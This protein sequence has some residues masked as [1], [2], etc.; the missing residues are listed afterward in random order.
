MTHTA[1]GDAIETTPTVHEIGPHEIDDALRQPGVL[2]IDFWAEWC[3]PCHAMTPILHELA[4][5]HA[6]TL[7]VLQVDVATFPEVGE[8]FDVQSLPTFA[9][10]ANG[11]LV[12]RMT[13]ARTKR[14]LDRAVR[15][16]TAGMS[17]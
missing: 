4:A 3:G 15:D 17:T 11:N 14:Q 5:D 6:G 16:A 13:G 12:S 7:R 2:L 10:F 9:L 8:R 1:G